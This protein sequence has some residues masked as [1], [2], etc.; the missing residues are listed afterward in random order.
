M[1][2]LMIILTIL[3]VSR[4]ELVA[5]TLAS[6]PQAS[7]QDLRTELKGTAAHG[8]ATYKVCERPA[9]MYSPL[10]NVQYTPQSLLLT[11][12]QSGYASHGGGSA[13]HWSSAGGKTKETEMSSNI[14][15]HSTSILLP[16]TQAEEADLA[17]A[18]PEEPL[19]QKVGW[20]GPPA[21]PFL[22]VGEVPW[23]GMLLLTGIYVLCRR[24]SI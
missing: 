3:F 9:A 20:D 22:P 10:K 17:Q 12:Q 18:T 15:F 19:M 14:V 5:Q 23:I 11:T 2:Q 13:Q 21:D 8:E 24:L 6:E 16:A 4:F 1:K 7:Y